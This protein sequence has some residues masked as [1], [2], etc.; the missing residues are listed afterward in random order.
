LGDDA[1]GDAS[2]F[3]LLVGPEDGVG[4]G[5]E[6]LVG[7]DRLGQG[8]E[9][10]ALGEHSAIAEHQVE[11]VAQAVLRAVAVLDEGLA[12]DD[13]CDRE[14]GL[15]ARAM[16]DHGD[17]QQ[18]VLLQVGLDV[19]VYERVAADGPSDLS[20]RGAGLVGPE[21]DEADPL[22]LALRVGVEHAGHVGFRLGDERG[23]DGRLAAVGGEGR[24]DG[25]EDQEQRR[26]GEGDSGCFQ[27]RSPSQEW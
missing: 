7:V 12:F 6:R 26:D 4:L 18:V 2:A 25:G 14:G 21:R 3:L 17:F 1:D 13:R 24:R 27:S 10:R 11:L 20:Q 19:Q 15:L 22:E 23:L 16:H 9:E 8:V 5:Q